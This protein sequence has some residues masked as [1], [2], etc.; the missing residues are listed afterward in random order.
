MITKKVIDTLY[1]RYSKRPNSAD[2]LNI[3]LLFESAHPVHGIVIEDERVVINSVEDNSPFHRIP[4][5]L[6]HSIVEF[7]E[8]VAIILHSSIIFLS[9]Y[10][11]DT[12]VS[13]HLKPLKPSIKDR[14]LG[15][16][17]K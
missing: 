7:D 12:P 13:V 11:S 17:S 10:D 15:I 16:L 8:A 2:D 3:A 6:I 9:R 4:L 5:K 14:F 1:K